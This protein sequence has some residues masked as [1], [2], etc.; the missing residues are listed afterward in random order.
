MMARWMG[1]LLGTLLAATAAAAGDWPGW[2]GPT[3]QGTSDEKEL[4]LRWGAP[5]GENVLWK[6]PLPGQAAGN[7]QDK[8]Q[9]SPIVCA[10]R[11]YVTVGFWPAG[12]SREEFPEHHVACY[13]ADDGTLLWDT[14]V[15]PGPWK[16]T[17]LRGGYTAPTPACD[18]KHVFVL[19][20]SAVLAALDLDGKIV[21]RKEIVPHNFD[22]AIGTSPVLYKDNI[23]LQ[24][25]QISGS[26]RFQAFDKAS[27]ELKW[28]KKRPDD[29]FSHST[30]VLVKVEGK[31]Q[32]LTAAAGRIEGVNPDDG[33]LLWWCAG[34]GDTVSPVLANGLVYC[35]SGRGGGAGIAV[36]PTGEGNVTRTLLAWRIEH[37]PEGFSSPV[38]VDGYLYR[39][40]NPGVLHC[41]RMKTGEKVYEERLSGVTTA[42]SPVA[43]ADG[44]IYIASA[45]K[46]FVIRAGAKFELLGSS[47][48]RDASP[49]SPAV[50]DGR[51]FLKGQRFL[52]CI[53]KK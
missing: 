6:K 29:G 49:A 7:Q 34:N 36:A 1:A 15:P 51:L 21:W 38:V 19:F 46:S 32:L 10:G 12:T 26:S 3:G 50:A 24:C 31:P 18:G 45:G 43:T 8:N 30:P 33:S 11:V 37:V 48:L 16:L 5:G 47:D 44:R 42:A 20:G 39:V 9:S 23:L 40:L 28:E 27:G 14:R 4:P 25:D 35:D 41:R 17:D 2:R 52:H 22:V 53:G 13:Q